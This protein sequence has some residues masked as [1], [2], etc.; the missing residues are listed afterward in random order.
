MELKQMRFVELDG[1]QLYPLL[2]FSLRIGFFYLPLYFISFFRTFT[3][4]VDSFLAYGKDE[5]K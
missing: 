4:L 2:A 3:L 5:K 1:F